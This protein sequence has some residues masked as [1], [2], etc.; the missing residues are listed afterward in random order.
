[1]AS[2]IGSRMTV[3]AFTIWA[4]KLT[5]SATALALIGFFFLA[6]SVAIAPFAGVIVD[7]SNR[8]R[9]M[10][11]SDTI[12]ALS[13]FAILLL[14]LAGNLQIWH[15]YLI[16]AINGLCNQVQVLAYGVSIPMLVR[17]QHYTRAIGMGSVLSYGSEIIGPALGAVLY[18]AIGLTGI[19]LIDLISFVIAIGTVLFVHIPQPPVSEVGRQS[20]GGI[21]HELA[22]GFRYILARKSLLTLLLLVSL[23]WLAHDIGNSLYSPMILARTG[24][25][26]EVLAK[27][28]SRGGSRRCDWG[29]TLERIERS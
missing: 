25:N 6:S 5:G 27:L 11:L 13:E 7:R 12:I 8:K 29:V 17:K 18:Y 10:M 23:F 26:A 19:L 1:M 24:S 9:L 4:W 3:F 28:R 2:I 21:R 20:R 22:F 15:L 14:H 16:A